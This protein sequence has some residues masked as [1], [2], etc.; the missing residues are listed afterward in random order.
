MNRSA[1]EERHAQASAHISLLEEQ[2]TESQ[3]ERQRALHSK[4]EYLSMA[5]FETGCLELENLL[6]ITTRDL[7]I[8]LGYLDTLQQEFVNARIDWYLQLE[9]KTKEAGQKLA[10][11]LH[12]LETQM[13][14]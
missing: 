7:N 12:R 13:F 4:N 5:R 6:D 1:R 11:W 14:K 9:G 10:G 8:V 3:R 2:L